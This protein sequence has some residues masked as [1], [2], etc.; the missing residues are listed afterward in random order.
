MELK[1]IACLLRAI[2]SRV[3]TIMLSDSV[4]A[5][6]RWVMFTTFD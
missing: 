6:T 5:A 2:L 1:D 3:L 4:C